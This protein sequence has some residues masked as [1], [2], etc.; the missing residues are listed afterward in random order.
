MNTPIDVIILASFLFTL[1]ASLLRNRPYY[2]RGCLFTCRMLH[3]C[4]FASLISVHSFNTSELACSKNL[5]PSWMRSL[6]LRVTQSAVCGGSQLTVG[7][8]TLRVSNSLPGVRCMPLSVCYCHRLQFRNGRI[9]QF[10]VEPTG[11]TRRAATGGHVGIV[12]QSC[13]SSH[14]SELRTASRTKHDKR[15]ALLTADAGDFSTVSL[16][17]FLGSFCACGVVRNYVC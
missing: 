11:T 7:V 16:R 4:N 17:R 5:K 15:T 6:R 13:C 1:Q 8:V 2:A 9:N 14:T 12:E 10:H 3:T